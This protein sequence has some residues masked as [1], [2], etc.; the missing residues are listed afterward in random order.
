MS[1]TIHDIAQNETYAFDIFQVGDGATIHGYSDAHACTVVKV[2]ANG[3]RAWLQRDTATRNPGFKP[4]ITPGGF[5][6][7]CTNQDEQTY[8]YKND[9]EGFTQSVSLRKW[10]GRYVWT[11][12]GSEPDGRQKASKGRREFYDYNF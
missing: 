6:G 8:T 1:N 5:S 12:S 10:R 3:K 7:H 2:S 11:V 4:E 9:P